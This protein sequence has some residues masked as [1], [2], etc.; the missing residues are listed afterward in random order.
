MYYAT[1]YYSHLTRY[2]ES[3]YWYRTTTSCNACILVHGT[4]FHKQLSQTF[5]AVPLN[6]LMQ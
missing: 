2:H 4:V 5:G 6:I 3:P 1:T